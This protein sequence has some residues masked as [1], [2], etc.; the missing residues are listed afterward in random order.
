M[1]GRA[2]DQSTG[3]GE[4]ATV[5]RHEG[6]R[7]FILYQPY[8]PRK[9]HASLMLSQQPIAIYLCLMPLN[10]ELPFAPT[11]QGES[12]AANRVAKDH[13]TNSAS[14]NDRESLQLWQGETSWEANQRH[15]TC[16]TIKSTL[17]GSPRHQWQCEDCHQ[18]QHHLAS[19]SVQ[20]TSQRAARGMNAKESQWPP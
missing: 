13:R 17:L 4:K 1:L 9:Y 18:P 11:T 15:T 16:T 20:T 12:C 8:A 6:P 3:L 2:D 19:R 7:V 10:N 14:E 5:A